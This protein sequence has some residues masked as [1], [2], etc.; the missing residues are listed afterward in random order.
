MVA[1]AG[2]RGGGG[3][4]GLGPPRAPAAGG[5]GR[6]HGDVGG[7]LDGA[8]PLL[9]AHGGV[10]GARPEAQEQVPEQALLEGGHGAAFAC[11]ASGGVRA[12][13]V[14][15]LVVL[16]E[17]RKMNGTMIRVIMLLEC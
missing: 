12:S 16:P 3:Q 7:A 17:L 5:C 14:V 9:E 4:D 15:S 10:E 2:R 8:L 1:G 13:H 11:R 6:C